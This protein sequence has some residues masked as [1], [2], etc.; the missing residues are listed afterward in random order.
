M[1]IYKTGKIAFF[2]KKTGL[3]SC[4]FTSD[5]G[6]SVLDIIYDMRLSRYVLCPIPR[7]QEVDCL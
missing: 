4:K 2:D 6:R 1:K 5:S 3:R 7:L